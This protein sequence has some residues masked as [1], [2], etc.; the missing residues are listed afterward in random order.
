MSV[1]VLTLP[2]LTILRQQATQYLDD[3]QL[4]AGV[5]LDPK[6]IDAMVECYCKGYLDR[7]HEE[8]GK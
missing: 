6:S 5:I 8:I 7:V 4:R 1:N 3:L 2:D